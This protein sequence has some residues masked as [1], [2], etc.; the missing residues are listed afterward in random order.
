[1][2]LC[3]WPHSGSVNGRALNRS[4][5]EFQKKYQLSG[6][7]KYFQ[8]IESLRP[9]KKKI[10]KKL[11]S[12]PKPVQFKNQ[13]V[14]I[15]SGLDL[16]P[17]ES[18]LLAKAIK[19]MMPWRK[20]PFNILGHHI[21]AEWRSD[22]KWQR[23][24]KHAGPLQGKVVL[25]IGCNNGYFLFP[26]ALQKPKYLL[27]IDPVVPYQSQFNLLNQFSPLPNTDFKL[28]GVQDLQYFDK[29][30]DVVFCMG[31]LYH[32]PDPIAILKTIYNAMRPG[33]LIIFECQGIQ[34]EGP[35]FLFPQTRYLNAPGH[36]FLP[37]KEALE[38]LIRRSGF[39]YVETFFE[40]KLTDEEQRT[41]THAPFDSLN[42]FLDKND[43][44]LTIEGHPA[45]WRYYVKARRARR[46]R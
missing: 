26:M 6:Y 31:I 1:M 45:P 5:K 34:K 27:G 17:P 44:N 41:S 13:T 3:Q 42:Q 16:T 39:Q 46:R 19:S 12:E 38:N 37:S 35:Y 18:A 2:N 32:H 4:I 8:A 33:A 10:K 15:G 36:W 14:Q 30:F 9:L 23:V 28:C 7:Q 20:G 25:D 29:V 40:T 21:E 11:S 22:L 24:K 43:P